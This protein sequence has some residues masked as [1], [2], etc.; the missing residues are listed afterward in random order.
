LLFDASRLFLPAGYSRSLRESMPE[1][2]PDWL[3]KAG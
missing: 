2:F 3:K 1:R